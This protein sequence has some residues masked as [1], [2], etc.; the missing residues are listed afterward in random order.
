MKTPNDKSTHSRIG[1]VLARS[2]RQ[3]RLAA[4]CGLLAVLGLALPGS[5][6]TNL[7]RYTFDEA[8]SGT[9]AALD[10]SG[11]SPQANGTFSGTGTRTTTTP[12]GYPTAAFD[13]G[14]GGGGFIDAGNVGKIDGLS[15]FT[16]T[17]WIRLYGAPVNGQV[18]LGKRDT[19]NTTGFVVLYGLPSV[20]T[21]AATNFTIKVRVGTGTGSGASA[22]L[23]A[24]NAWV[25]VAVTYDGT[26]VSSNLKFYKGGPATAVSA[27][28]TRTYNLG[29]ALANSE[30]FRI[31]ASSA[32]A[33]TVSAMVDDVRV[34]NDALALTFLEGIRLANVPPTTALWWDRNGTT[35]GATNSPDGTAN[36][37]WSGSG[38][39]TGN[40][41]SSDPT[42]SIG[43]QQWNE[44]NAAN[45][46]AG[47]DTTNSYTVTVNNAPTASAVNIE[48][49]KVTFNTSTVTLVGGASVD[50]ASGASATFNTATISG[51]AGLTKTGDGTLT[52]NQANGYSGGTTVSAGTLALG[53]SGGISGSVAVSGGATL[54]GRGTINGLVT[55]ASGAT[56]APGSSVG[57]I[58]FNDGLILAGNLFI[59]VDKSLS[60]SND[61]AMVT[62]TLT[63]AGT[64][65]LT[66]TNLGATPLIAGD[67][68]TLFSQPLT[69]GSALT[70]VSDGGVVW[71]NKLEVDG[72]IQV[73]SVPQTGPS[74]LQWAVTGGNTLGFT[75]T[76]ANVKLQAQTNAAGIVLGDTNWFDYPGGGSSP[77]N[78]TIDPANPAVFFRL[79]S[80]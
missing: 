45:F 24:D 17:A 53:P 71:T 29:T 30:P 51:T 32:G 22:D 62:G 78:V 52:L 12:G 75:W 19:G 77:V 36:G 26:A 56:L 46:A 27:A 50:V 47:T 41:W 79:R 67:S 44:G 40:N 3:S 69:N 37:V 38:V 23:N 80:Q 35:P 57:T 4:I 61:M 72:S 9:T 70:I 74:Y 68:F 39:M 15:K 1:D 31:C 6:Q 2:V 43:T 58:T 33:A 18:L 66:V 13:A 16:I 54:M 42:G 25:F 21:L 55:V 34:Y 28:T 64:G 14:T 49:S 8:T 10:M 63:N 76:N 20:G 7:L 59:E 60:P 5:A 73:V 11:S 65:T 48:E